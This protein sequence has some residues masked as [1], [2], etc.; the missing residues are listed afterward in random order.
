[1]SLAPAGLPVYRVRNKKRFPLGTAYTEIAAWL[2]RFYQSPRG[3]PRPGPGG[4]GWTPRSPLAVVFAVGLVLLGGFCSGGSGCPPIRRS[5]GLCRPPGT[6]RRAAG[7]PVGG[8][9]RG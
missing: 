7:S 4:R 1:M 2:G 5:R 9:E 3:L 8:D 6:R